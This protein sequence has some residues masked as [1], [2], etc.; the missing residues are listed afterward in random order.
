MSGM[1][2]KGLRRGIHNCVE[3]NDIIVTCKG[4]DDI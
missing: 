4:L 2:D 1:C 3:L